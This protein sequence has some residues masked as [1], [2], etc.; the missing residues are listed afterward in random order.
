MGTIIF[1][2]ARGQT[3]ALCMLGQH[4]SLSYSSSSQFRV[5]AALLHTGHSLWF[6]AS[7]C[8]PFEPECSNSNI[9][10]FQLWPG[11]CSCSCFIGKET[12]LGGPKKLSEGHKAIDSKSQP[13][14]P[15]LKSNVFARRLFSNCSSKITSVPR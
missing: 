1:C 7:T 15:N 6:W 10:I 14:L 2:G 9:P 12:V 5:L 3:R 11:L 4:C 13:G 8:S